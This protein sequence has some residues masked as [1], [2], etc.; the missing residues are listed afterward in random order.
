MNDVKRYRIEF[1]RN[2]IFTATYPRRKKRY[3]KDILFTKVYWENCLRLTN[4]I[5]EG[6]IPI[7]STPSSTNSDNIICVEYTLKVIFHLSA[8]CMIYSSYPEISVPIFIGTIPFREA[9]NQQQITPTAPGENDI[10]PASSNGDLTPLDN[11]IG[12]FN[13]G[14]DFYNT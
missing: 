13:F 12:K 4:R 14:E 1:S 7:P 10:I 11:E 9:T 5:I 6:E 8:I 2:I 3:T